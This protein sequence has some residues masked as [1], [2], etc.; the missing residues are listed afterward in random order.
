M[1][2]IIII[3][4]IIIYTVFYFT[5]D[6]E[7]LSQDLDSNYEILPESVINEHPG[8]FKSG[9]TR[10]FTER[11]F[12]ENDIGIRRQIGLMILSAMIVI[13]IITGINSLMNIS[14]YNTEDF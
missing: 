5:F 8:V 11:I 13:M 2:I 3:A 4:T 1:I 7:L 14:S 10:S 9:D 12:M 6:H